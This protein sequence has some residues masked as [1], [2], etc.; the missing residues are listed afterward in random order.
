M[1]LRKS[2][3]DIV[4]EICNDPSPEVT[5][6]EIVHR[7]GGRAFGA[8]FFLFS[9]PNWLPLPPGSSAILALPLLFLG[10]QVAMGVHRPWLPHFVDSRPLRRSDLAGGLRKML[11]TL[12]RIEHLSRPRLP[13]LIGPAGDRLI[14]LTITILALVMLLPIPLGNMAPA[15]AV[16]AFGLGMVQR[17]GVLAVAGYLITAISAGLLVI[18]LQALLLLM[19]GVM[20][21]VGGG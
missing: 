12:E 21:A 13:F 11:P 18:G 17:D 20:G 3:S 8:L 7:F 10:P 1:E 9:V 19:R 2:L 5:V 15:A 4:G 16:A 6:G 14:G